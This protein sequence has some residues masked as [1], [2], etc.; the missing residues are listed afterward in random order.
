MSIY[1]QHGYGKSDKI[2]RGI[3]NGNIEGIILSPKDENPENMKHFIN[4][5]RNDY[6]DIEMLFDPQFYV[7]TL[8]PAREGYLLKYDY[9]KSSLI[10]ANFMKHT[11]IL[12]YITKTIDYQYELNLPKIVSSTIIVDDFNDPWSQISL[13]MAQEAEVYNSSKDNPKPLIISL[14]FNETALKDGKAVDEYLDM[15]S[16]LNVTG[17]YILIRRE[18]RNSAFD[19]E[20][21]ILSRF[22]Y[23]NYTL[24]YINQ[25]EIILGCTDFVGI[26]IYCT[27]IRAISTGWFTGLK[28]FTLSRF[29]PSSGGRRPLPRY[30]SK[31]LLNCILQIPELQTIYELG[32]IDSVLSN[33]KYDSIL[34][35]NP[36]RVLWPSDI[37]CLQHWQVLDA[38]TKRIDEFKSISE[39]LDYFSELILET[40]KLYSDLEDSTMIWETSHNYLEQWTIGINDF[41]TKIGV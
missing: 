2:N 29:Q 33:T 10:R 22:M 15:L 26:P 23:M 41:R 21:N 20:P 38:I 30:T 4:T 8:I 36:G 9:Y 32:M 18:G 6:K 24:S 37:E 40:K 12:E 17:F 14:C 25:Y 11:D 31:G 34:K 19:I 39:K 1:A 16:L 5:I 7:S 3:E 27:G 13:T 28:Q 35:I